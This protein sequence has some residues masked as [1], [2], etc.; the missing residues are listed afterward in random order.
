MRYNMKGACHG[1]QCMWLSV[2]TRTSLTRHPVLCPLCHRKQVHPCHF[3]HRGHSFPRA[4]SGFL[5]GT[6]KQ[7][8]FHIAA[9]NF[10]LTEL[11]EGGKFSEFIAGELRLKTS[12]ATVPRAQS[13]NHGVKIGT[14]LWSPCAHLRSE[15]SVT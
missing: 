15:F 9:L 10:F 2:T 13:F 14:W 12:E 1:I 7:S 11:F 3:A 6:R 4:S 8:A 5:P